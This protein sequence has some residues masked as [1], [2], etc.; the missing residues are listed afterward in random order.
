MAFHTVEAGFEAF[1]R[2]HCAFYAR[3]AERFQP[4]QVE[5]IF[6]RHVLDFIHVL[7]DYFFQ[8]Q[9]GRSLRDR[10]AVTFKA[11]IGNDI[12]LIHIEHDPQFIAAGRVFILIAVV[13]GIQ[14][15]AVSRVFVMLNDQF[16][17][18]IVQK[19]LRL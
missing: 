13:A 2:K 12:I 4:K 18:H 14:L 8:E 7:P 9:I 10:A 16:A 3:R 17:V 15:P 11:G 6:F 1:E 5:H 19:Y